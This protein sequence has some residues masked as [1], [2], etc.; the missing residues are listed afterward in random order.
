[1]RRFVLFIIVSCLIGYGYYQY[2]R[3]EDRKTEGFRLERIA[4]T[5]PDDPQWDVEVSAENVAQAKIILSQPYHYL[6][7]GFQ[8]Y[9]FLSEDKKY[10]LKFIRQQR[11]RPPMI[12][13]VMP[14]VGPFKS[15]IEERAAQGKKRAG[16][17]FRS[18]KVAFEAAPHETGIVL[19]HLNKTQSIYPIVTIYDKAGTKYEVALDSHEFILQEKA[20]LIKPV[21]QQ[22]MKEGK[23]DEACRRIDQIF[24]LLYT[25]AKKG[26]ADNDMQ[27]IRK[28]NLGFLPDRAIYIDTGKITLKESIKTKERFKEDLERLKPLYEW[29]K[30]YPPLAEHFVQEQLRVLDSF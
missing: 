6:G 10:V 29:L 14:N 12:C 24:A 21:F 1:M 18:L 23:I 2:C 5:F 19:V 26:V 28:N 15:Y 8:C 13:D 3:Y 25:C 16:Y 20:E 9:A 22:L 30:E 17:L 27:L 4:Q 11:L 7:H